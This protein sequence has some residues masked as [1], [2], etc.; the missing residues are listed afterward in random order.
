MISTLWLRPVSGLLVLLA[1]M[2]AAP[3]QTKGPTQTGPSPSD[4]ES[5]VEAR[6]A[7]IQQAAQQ[8][9]PEKVFSF[10][11]E[12]DQ[13]ALVQNGKLLLTRQA[14]LQSTKRG[15]EG[16][17]SIAYQF[18]QQH[19]TMLSPTI[20]LVTGEGVSTATTNDGRTLSTRFAQSIV[21]VLADG[22]WKVFHAHR[23]FPPTR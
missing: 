20:A 11:L 9:D 22:Q 12:N 8:L 6:L 1:A 21:L 10:V 18:D 16:L 14:A 4:A 2:T 5:A 7:E 13:G 17:N 19:I 3:G 23:S 15:F